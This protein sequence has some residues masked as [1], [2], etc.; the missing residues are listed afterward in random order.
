MKKI[1]ANFKLNENQIK[2]KLNNFPEN[3]DFDTLIDSDCKVFNKLGQPVL[4]FI[5]NYIEPETLKKAFDSMESSA[6]P[7]NNRGMASGGIR[8][9]G[10][11]KDGTKTKMSYVYPKGTTDFSNETRLQVLSG[12][13][14][15]FDRSAH[16]DICR[17]TAFNKHSIEK[18][19]KALPLI[20]SVDKGF[21]EFVPERYKKQ[22]QMI[23]A[24]DPNYRIGETAFT[25]ITINKDYRTAYHYDAGDY[26]KGFGNLVAYCRDIKPM[27]LVLPRYGVGVN[28]TTN[29]LL[30]LNVHELH[31]NTEFIPDG[32]RPVRLSFVM[33]YRENMWK[34]LPPKEE[35]KR[36]QT[37]QRIVAQKYLMGEK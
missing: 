33:Y 24:T 37:N 36:I 16:Y 10:T 26:P 11:L 25:T 14:G 35:L 3:G 7:T 34:C 17:K 31:G 13:A 19:N 4:Y 27:H 20:N 29:D 18:F 28:L 21:K 23:K 12:I 32:P 15:Y 9:S 6:K 2:Q 30:L 22:K 5:K 1:I 8:H